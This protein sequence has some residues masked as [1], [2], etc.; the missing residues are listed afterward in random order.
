MTMKFRTISR[1]RHAGRRARS[2]QIIKQHGASKS[3]GV[4]RDGEKRGKAKRS[5]TR[6]GRVGRRR[7]KISSD[8]SQISPRSVSRSCPVNRKAGY[9]FHDEEKEVGGGFVDVS[10]SL[11]GTR[12]LH[13]RQVDRSRAAP[14]SLV[15]S[16]YL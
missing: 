11:Y 4:R 7:R 1:T 3:E 5:G 12:G 15:P 8:V 6:D 14:Y 16:P 10:S 13:P 2:R 9:S